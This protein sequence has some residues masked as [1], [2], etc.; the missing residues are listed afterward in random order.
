MAC[1][2]LVAEGMQITELSE[3]LIY[4]LKGVIPPPEPRPSHAE[5]EA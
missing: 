2:V 4:N 5:Q 1:K 3:E